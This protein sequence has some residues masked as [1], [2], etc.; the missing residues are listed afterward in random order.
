MTFKITEYVKNKI[1]YS[2]QLKVSGKQKVRTF[3]ITQYIKN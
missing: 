2:L 3:Q 1:K